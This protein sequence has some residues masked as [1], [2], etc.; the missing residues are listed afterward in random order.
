MQNVGAIQS[1]AAETF[2]TPLR[3]KVSA[4]ESTVDMTS[5]C[6]SMICE[7]LENLAKNGGV[8]VMTPRQSS[9]PVT[10]LSNHAEILCNAIQLLQE[11]IR[12]SSA[13]LHDCE[14]LSSALR[15][16]NQQLLSERKSFLDKEQAQTLEANRTDLK[17]SQ[18]ISGFEGQIE[19]M[20]ATLLSSQLKYQELEE[21]HRRNVIHVLCFS[22]CISILYL[23]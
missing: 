9:D 6:V 16:E 22:A 12:L 3:N 20:S 23:T 8:F 5:E 15:Q 19:V 17:H 13:I 1:L 4:Q 7:T 11:K 10:T 2:L 21:L 18:M 14:A